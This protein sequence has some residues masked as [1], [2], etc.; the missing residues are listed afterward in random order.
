[1]CTR[2]C[3]HGS[4]RH[5][6]AAGPGAPRPRVA[7]FA[8]ARG[9]HAADTAGWSR[10]HSSPAHTRGTRRLTAALQRRSQ[11][12]HERVRGRGAARTL[13]YPRSQ[14]LTRTRGPRIHAHALTLR[15][16]GSL[17][18]S[19]ARSAPLP[20]HRTL[21]RPHPHRRRSPYPRPPPPPPPPPRS[22]PRG[23]RLRRCELATP[24]STPRSSAHARYPTLPP[25]LSRGRPAAS[26]RRRRP[27]HRRRRRWL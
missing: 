6:R 14:L 27:H 25:L 21:L 23:E 1:M 2:R 3:A 5:A 22:L 24:R 7:L 16:G 8:R 11:L 18:H 26:P 9:E 13:A 4:T 19:H 10:P 17:C 20:S 15:R 12:S